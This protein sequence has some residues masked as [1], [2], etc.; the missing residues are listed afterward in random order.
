[1]MNKLF[2][3]MIIMGCAVG[4]ICG[5]GAAVSEAVFNGASEA[6]RLLITIGGAVCLWSGLMRIIER[7]NMLGGVCRVISPVM[8]RLFPDIRPESPAMSSIVMNI[9]A[10]LLGLANAATPIGIR[11]MEQMKEQGGGSD[12]ADRSMIMF[13]VMNTASFQLMSSSLIA[14][15]IEAGS[16]NPFEVTAPIWL[17]SAICLFSAILTAKVCGAVKK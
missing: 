11:A 2:A 8:K 9:A 7:S 14:L 10:N 6:V 13:V 17:A 12:T 15:R 1:M 3:A 4:F 16:E 5:R